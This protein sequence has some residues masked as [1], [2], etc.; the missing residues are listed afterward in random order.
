MASGQSFHPSK[1]MAWFVSDVHLVGENDPRGQ[2]F[3]QFLRS[4][5]LQVCTH[6]FLVGD[7]FDLWIS[8]HRYFVQKF[9]AIL[10]QLK[11]LRDQKVQIHYFE[12]NHDL[13]L[14][15]YFSHELELNVHVGPEYFELGP[16]LVRVEHGDQMD[17]EDR[18]YRFLRW[19]LRTPVMVFVARNL[20]GPVVAGIGEFLSRRSRTYTSTLKTISPVRTIEKI[21]AHAHAKASQRICDLFVSGHVHEQDDYSFVTGGVSVRAVNLGTWLK[22]YAAFRVTETRHEFVELNGTVK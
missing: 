11:R 18:G 21:R 7:I 17:P 22:S 15:D 10:E 1:V 3:L 19:L 16:W 4:L 20:P 2:A 6:L 12:G 9:P 13:Y 14:H 5:N 8:N